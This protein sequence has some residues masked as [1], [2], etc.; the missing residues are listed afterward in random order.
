MKPI[1]FRTGAEFRAWLA[2]HCGDATEIL[3]L[4]HKKSSGKGGISYAEALDEALS[5]GWIDGVRKGHG[6]ESYTIRFTPRKPGSIWSRVNVRH[7]E[8]LIREGRMQP[9]GAEAFRA[10]TKARTGVYSFENHVTQLPPELERPFQARKPA[11]TFFQ[12]QPPGYR[13]IV[14][15]WIVSAKQEATR[16]RRLDRVIDVSAKRQRVDLMRPFANS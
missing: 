2:A 16:Q 4:L 6:P 3:V 14:T 12:E 11:W 5:Q 1:A 7:A 9:A 8:R 13:R 15:W 10:R